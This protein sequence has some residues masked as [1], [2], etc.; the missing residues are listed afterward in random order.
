MDS[1]YEVDI[2]GLL[3]AVRHSDHVIVRFST[4]AQRLFVDF[5]TGDGQ[6]PG[7]FVLPLAETLEQRLASIT[8]ARPQL[9]RPDRL[10]VMAW[11]LRV[12]GLDRL[13]FV[14][15]VRHRLAAL[16]AFEAVGALDRAMAELAA[17]EE[18]EL[19]RAVTGEGYRTLWPGGGAAAT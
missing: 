7:V 12:R 15:A 19:H 9:P 10:H 14:E 6:G 17:A 1:A 8:A 11:P 5:R 18:A 3:Q 2:D 16:D 13:G 4:L